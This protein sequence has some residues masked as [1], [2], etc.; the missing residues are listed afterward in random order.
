MNKRK[1]L[2]LASV[3][4]AGMLIAPFTSCAPKVTTAAKTTVFTPYSLPAL[5]YSFDALE[6][7]IDK[8]T[9][10]IHHDRHH[11]AYINKLNEALPN[12]PYIGLSLTQLLAE[13]KPT[14]SA[15]R[16]NGGGHYNH[17]LFWQ[18]LTP[19]SEGK[20]VGKLAEAINSTFGSFEKWQEQFTTA[21]KSVFGSGWVWLALD[22]NNK[23]FISTTPNQDNPLMKNIVTNTGTPLLGL[24]VWEHAYYLKYQNLRADYIKNFY[25][26]IAWGEVEKRYV[27]ALKS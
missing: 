7:Y 20:P 21:S 17:E 18:I 24:D 12:S 9:M 6:P 13:I 14:D 26:I 2:Q 27:A 11:A 19:K 3:A 1:F 23:L 22:N 4:S 8:L 16:N 5:P 15:L 25:N 10:E